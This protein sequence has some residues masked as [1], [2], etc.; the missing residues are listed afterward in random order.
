MNPRDEVLSPTAAGPAALPRQPA[1]PPCAPAA[2]PPTAE[3]V[4]RWVAAGPGPWFPSAHAKQTGTPRDSLDDPLAQLRLADLVEIVA[5]VRGAGQ[6]YALTAAGRATLAGTPLPPPPEP[7]EPPAVTPVRAEFPDVHPPVVT[8]AVLIAT[9]LWFFVGLVFAMRVGVPAGEY[10]ARGNPEALAR[11]G[12]VTAPDLLRGEWWRLATCCF[13]HFGAVHLVLNMFVLGGVG[14]LAELLW[15]RGRTAVVYAVSG[16]GGSCLAMAL[17]PTVEGGAVVMLAGASGAVW[18][19]STSLLAWLLI[20]GSRLPPVLAGDLFRRLCVML[21]VNAAA[22]FLP[23]VSWQAHLGG[24]VAGFVTA[25]LLSAAAGRDRSRR[26]AAVAVLVLLPVVSVMG[27]LTAVRSAPAWVALRERVA[28]AEAARR[29]EGEQARWRELQDRVNELVPPLAPSAVAPVDR[30]AVMLRALGPRG[31][32][33]TTALWAKAAA[34]R[35]VAARAE[36]GLSGPPTGVAEADRRREQ[37]RAYCAARGRAF[38]LLLGL[39]TGPGTPD[40]QAWQAWGDA[41][42]DADRLWDAIPKK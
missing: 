23:N 31:F 10:L 8:P 25:A 11:L 3:A 21:A 42:R 12:A 1:E 30:S 14:P 41:R 4:L 15:G 34:L 27:L 33:Q 16:L 7:A 22:S 40:A 32:F 39:L 13:V 6:G 5:W 2:D 35:A 38:E 9:V 18:G 17:N 28:R 19:V 24:G 20:H 37:F 36:A 29:Q 26:L